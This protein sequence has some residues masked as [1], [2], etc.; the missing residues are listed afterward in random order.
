MLTEGK[1]ENSDVQNKTS[2]LSYHP[3]MCV[4]V[5]V[6]MGEQIALFSFK[7]I[8]LGV[9]GR[10]PIGRWTCGPKLGTV[11]QAEDNRLGAVSVSLWPLQLWEGPRCLRR[12]LG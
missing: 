8:E 10:C 2:H 6:F 4:C 5:C 12:G 11:S 1:L 7:H 3:Q 9:Q